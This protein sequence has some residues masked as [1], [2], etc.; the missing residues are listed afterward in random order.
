VNQYRNQFTKL[1]GQLTAPLAFI[2]EIGD[3]RS[4]RLAASFLLIIFAIDLTGALAR[5]QRLGWAGAFSGGL[6]LSL[7]STL[8][9]YP[10]A[11]TKWYRW[12]V[13][14]FSISF[15]ATAYFSIITEGTLAD[16]GAIIL[17]YVPIS[18]IVASAFLSPW[19]VFLLTI[20]NVSAY[21]LA[22]LIDSTLPTTLNVEMGAILLIGFVLI[23]LANFQT[24][25]EKAR[26]KDL[27]EINQH[28][29][30]TSQQ[31]EQ[32]VAELERF[33]YTA[34]HDLKSPLVTIKGFKCNRERKAP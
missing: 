19:V 14:I 1:W 4:A 28:L 5:V 11:R 8:I 23:T 18:L 29:K 9:A 25:L 22:T 15:S 13:F 31:L 3:Q 12:A 21:L 7:L 34:S 26:L 20:L 2:K 33:T 6:G 30:N 17:I 27:Q 16:Q 10:L 32:K 24:L